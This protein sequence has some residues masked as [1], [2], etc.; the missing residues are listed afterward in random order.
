[1]PAARRGDNESLNDRCDLLA[2]VVTARP[3]S[4]GVFDRLAVNAPSRWAR[5]T[6]GRLARLQQQ[7][8]ID[9]LQCA[10]VAPRIKITL[11]RRVVWKIARQHSPLTTRPRDVEQSVDHRQQRGLARSPQPPRR[12]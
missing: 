3:A 12:G 4:L 2:G 5:L 6:A 8:E 9:P 7:F 1:M 10:I 11:D